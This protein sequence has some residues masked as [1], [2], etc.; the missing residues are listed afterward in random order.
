[1]KT[2]IYIPC[3]YRAGR[4]LWPPTTPSCWYYWLHKNLWNYFSGLQC[5]VI[6][7]AGPRSSNLED[8]VDRF[9]DVNMRYSTKK[10]SRELKKADLVV[11]DSVSTPFMEATMLGKRVICVVPRQD[12]KYIY[13]SD[14]KERVSFV[15]L[16]DVFNTIA[17]QVDYVIEQRWGDYV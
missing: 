7:K 6:W 5:K 10:L 1:M 15:G 16:W 3:I 2:I 17:D 11:V 9:R 4:G 12:K 8:P 13:S 14:I